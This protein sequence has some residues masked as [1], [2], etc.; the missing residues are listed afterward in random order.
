MTQNPRDKKKKKKLSYSLVRPNWCCPIVYY[1]HY[2]NFPGDL[3]ATSMHFILSSS[4]FTRLVYAQEVL[5][6]IAAMMKTVKSVYILHQAK[7]SAL[8]ALTILLALALHQW[9]Q[10]TVVSVHPWLP[11]SAAYCARA[12]A[13]CSCSFTHK[14]RA[15]CF[16]LFL[17]LWCRT[18]LHLPT[19]PKNALCARL[20]SRSLPH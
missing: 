10:S 4:I 2:P 17:R 7:F 3:N 16:L 13:L 11:P 12:P 1:T 19:P 18:W 6:A 15:F 20:V 5:R 8:C 14:M 9:M